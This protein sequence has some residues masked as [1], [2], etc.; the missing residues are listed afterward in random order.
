METFIEN[1]GGVL[2]EK[3]DFQ[4]PPLK[5]LPTV[6]GMRVTLNKMNRQKH[7][8]SYFVTNDPLRTRFAKKIVT[9][10][11]TIIRVRKS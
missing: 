7:F 1:L 8:R 3:G 6:F 9:G 10:K 4:H 5:K 11:K 2:F